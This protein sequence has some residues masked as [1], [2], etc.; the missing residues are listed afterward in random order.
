[1]NV[2]QSDQS[3]H[4]TCA[5]GRAASIK[6]AM[7]MNM[8]MSLLEKKRQLRRDVTRRPSEVRLIGQHTSHF[9]ARVELAWQDVR[10][11]HW[12]QPLHTHWSLPSSQRGRWRVPGC[13]GGGGSGV[14]DVPGTHGTRQG[15]QSGR[16]HVGLEQLRDSR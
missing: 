10:R 6:Q 15:R 16:D 7:N 14:T 2:S 3:I 11:R 13:A 5:V 8:N 12:I 1:M 4:C 9:E